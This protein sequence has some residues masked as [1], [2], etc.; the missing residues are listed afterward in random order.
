M[1]VL[2]QCHFYALR[3][4]RLIKI[5]QYGMYEIHE[6]TTSKWRIYVGFVVDKVALG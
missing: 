1:H 5:E 6:Y 3:L 2:E 4:M